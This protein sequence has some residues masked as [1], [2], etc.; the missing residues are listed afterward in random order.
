MALLSKKELLAKEEL[1]IVKVP[2]GGN[3]F[4]FVRQ[5]TGRERD[6]WEQSL[7]TKIRNNKG[8]VTG[9]EVNLDDFRAKLAV[10]TICD[11]KG[12]LLLEPNDYAVLSQHK[13]AKTL[14][15]IINIAQEINKISKEDKENL[16]KN[17]KAAQSGDST[18]DSAGK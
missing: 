8:E 13:S 5:M 4:V 10:L 6:K 7:R 11:E 1:K 15:T 12:E 14:E 9:G 18:S 17:S 2:L 3:D 16:V